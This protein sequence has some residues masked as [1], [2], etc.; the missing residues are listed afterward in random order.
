MDVTNYTYICIYV[1][2]VIILF[3]YFLFM[4]S[5]INFSKVSNDKLISVL[6]FNARLNMRLPKRLV[7]CQWSL[8][9]LAL[10]RGTTSLDT[11]QVTRIFFN[12][13]GEN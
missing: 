10:L 6:I 1:L 5:S 8:P 12:T 2:I 3:V 7:P 9:N 13:K 4:N 11:A